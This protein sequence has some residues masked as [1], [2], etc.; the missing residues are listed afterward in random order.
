[1]EHS[2][3]RERLRT[4]VLSNGLESMLPHEVLELLLCY[5]IPRRDVNPLAHQLLNHFG[6]LHAVLDADAES[7][8]QIPGISTQTAVLLTM[9]PQLFRF[10]ALDKTGNHPVLSTR[11]AA[12]A[13]CANLFWGITQEALFM[14]CLDAQGR[15]LRKVLLHEGTIDQITVYPRNVVQAALQFSA[16]SVIFSHNHPSGICEPS[17]ADIQM[18]AELIRTLQGISISVLDHIIVADGE[19]VSMRSGGFL[20]LENPQ[21]VPACAAENASPMRNITRT[22]KRKP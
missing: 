8:M 9:I 21:E 3:H 22:S 15:L 7:L 20:H 5:A 11:Q 16:C 12:C 1:M 6:S 14:L 10:Y 19:G 17:E 2:G 13:Y 18:T 4:R